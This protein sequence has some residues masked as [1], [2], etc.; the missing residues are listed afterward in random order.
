V[1]C[2]QEVASSSELDANESRAVLSKNALSLFPRFA[3]QARNPKA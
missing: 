3:D 2:R 1:T